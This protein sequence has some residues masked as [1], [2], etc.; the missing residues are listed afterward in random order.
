M[1]IFLLIE[2]S[3][4][5]SSKNSFAYGEPSIPE[6]MA[7]SKTL[8]LGLFSSNKQSTRQ[9]DFLKNIFHVQ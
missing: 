3:G 9:K 1:L 5:S 8:E 2:L 4:I 6:N 7:F